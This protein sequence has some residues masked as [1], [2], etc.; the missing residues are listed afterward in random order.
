MAWSSAGRFLLVFA[1]G[2]GALF[3]GALLLKLLAPSSEPASNALEALWWSWGR[4]ADPGSGAADQ[5]TGVR[6]AEIV[7]TLSGVL[8]FALLIGFVSETVQEKIGNLRKGKSL[9]VERDHT[10]I[11]GFNDR[12]RCIIA[13][14][15]EANESRGDSCVVILSEQDK[16][17]VIDALIGAFGKPKVRTTRIV[18]R[19]GSAFVA[20]DLLN[21]SAHHARSIVLLADD[22][23]SQGD[24]R[25]VK[26]VLALTRGLGTPLLGHVVAELSD[27]DHRDVL[28]SLESA[29]LEIVVAREFLAR[30]LV[31]TAR[32][33]GLAQVYAMLLSFE[34]DEFYLVDVPSVFFGRTFDEV[35]LQVPQG[36]VVGYVS[37]QRKSERKRHVWLNPP[38][39]TVLTEG[40]RLALLLEDDSVTISPR[41]L[42]VRGSLPQFSHHPI[43]IQQEH[44][45]ILGFHDEL[46]EMLRELD[47]YVAAG[48][49]VT[50]VSS[51]DPAVIAR[52]L[53]RFVNH[54]NHLK[55]EHVEGDP[56]TKRDIE[57][58]CGA[59]FDSAIVL[60]DASE[61]RST[62]D[63]DARTLM[64]V[65][66][67]RSLAKGDPRI[68]SEIR[69]PRTKELATVADV[70]DFV[71]SDELV[72]GLLAQVSE[73][74]EL[75]ALWED[76]CSADGS[77]IYLKPASK[78][79]APSET[80]TFADLMARARARKEIAIGYKLA[81]LERHADKAYGITLNPHDK[82]VALP[83]SVE[84]RVIVI[85]EHER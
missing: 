15:A 35:C 3:M 68:I 65:L 73:N 43:V 28:T 10:L 30:L 61:S 7:T 47:H 20:N 72:S 32:Q 64:S 80:V 39:D 17:T 76:L 69:N 22:G 37:K 45:L 82:E 11:L 52:R 55:I 59:G 60:A 53:S 25:V 9:V 24:V 77:E 12:A 70:T 58:L 57:P 5:G 13:E 1:L 51:L 34:G 42:V 63:T 4:V 23:A 16:E 67:V 83:L 19:Y 81:R 14:L 56:T 33:T 50:I 46:G 41:P 21:V 31:Q 40:D 85:A 27:I 18:V 8:L 6:I 54:L 71:V 66:L 78:Y 62:D 38:G 79:L 74:R 29:H 2:V 84:D 36:V 75:C 48:S 26:S 49:R 44:I